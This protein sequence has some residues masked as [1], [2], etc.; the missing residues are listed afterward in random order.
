[1][2]YPSGDDLWSASANCR[3][4]A[5]PRLSA[6]DDFDSEC[7]STTK[8]GVDGIEKTAFDVPISHIRSGVWGISGDWNPQ[9]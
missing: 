8:E 7:F 2:S 3:I 6:L 9:S 5:L 4:D 1:M